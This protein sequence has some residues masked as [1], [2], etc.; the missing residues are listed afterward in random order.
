MNALYEPMYIDNMNT[1]IPFPIMDVFTS[2]NNIAL[3]LFVI[4]MESLNIIYHTA[5]FI[6]TEAITFVDTNLSFTEKIL[7][8]FCL[9]NLILLFIM[10]IIYV[11]DMQKIQFTIDQLQKRQDQLE[12]QEELKYEFHNDTLIGIYAKIKE[13]NKAYDHVSDLEDR[14]D[15]I[16]Q[17]IDAMEYKTKK[18]GGKKYN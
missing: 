5:S 12:K 7:L 2:F 17:H 16:M 11:N 3:S 14:V 9:Y 4:A 8:C 1:V 6:I 10:D 18:F 13:F 15:I